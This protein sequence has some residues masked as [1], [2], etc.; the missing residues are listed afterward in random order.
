MKITKLLL[1]DLSFDQIDYCDS[2]IK[3]VITNAK[4]SYYRQKSKAKKYEIVFVDFKTYENEIP[5]GDDLYEK[6]FAAYI[7][8]NNVIITVHNPDLAEAL[9]GL[10]EI[11]RMVVLRC[12]VLGEKAI[13]IAKE[14]DVSAPMI[15]KHKQKALEI[16][17]KRMSEK[18]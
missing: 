7:N 13:D 1:E 9:S 15:T 4:K 17:K 16:I 5:H 6:G 14:L 3:K 10:N 12:V 8:V 2:Y 11:Q 18:Q